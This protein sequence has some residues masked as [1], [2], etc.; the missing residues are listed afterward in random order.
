M[1]PNDID[2]FKSDGERQ[3]Y[4]FLESVAKPDSQYISW[5]LP[6]IKG[7]EPDFLL[8]HDSVGLIVFE[9]KDWALEQIR[10]ANPQHF[11]LDIGAKTEHRKNPFQQARDYIYYVMDTIEEDGRLVSKEPMSYGKPKIPMDYGVI[12]PNINK[13]EYTQKGFNK[14]R[15]VSSFRNGHYLR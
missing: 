12:F 3:F 8:F 6:D 2:E 4:K 5:Y 9:V 10:E 14:V 15:R 11:V 7:K 13:Y 1:I